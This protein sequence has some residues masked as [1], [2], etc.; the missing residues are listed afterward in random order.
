MKALIVDR[1]GHLSVSEIRQPDPGE[2]EA[3]VKTRVCG[4]CNST[5]RHVIDGTMPYHSQYPAILGHESVG[6]IVAVGR[7][8]RALRPG[9]RVTRSSAIFAGETRDG[10]AS[11]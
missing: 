10:I 1:P 2:H 8:C 6:E 7:R 3:L 5:D 4:I 11:A 9:M